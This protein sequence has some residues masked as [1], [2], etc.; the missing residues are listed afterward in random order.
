MDHAMEQA[1]GGATATPESPV[2]LQIVHGNPTPEELA[3]LV[4]V[5]AARS[6]DAD[7][8]PAPR[9]LWSTPALRGGHHPA[10]GAWRASALPR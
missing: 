10:P 3:A 4:A 5:A 1:T 2:A 8:S 7:S 6:G 9:S